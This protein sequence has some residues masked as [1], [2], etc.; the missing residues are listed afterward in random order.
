MVQSVAFFNRAVPSF[1]IVAAW[2]FGGLLEVAEWARA[3]S[4][5]AGFVG[6]VL[7]LPRSVKQKGTA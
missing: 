3:E 4:S 7:L 6:Q 1:H 2:V 5:L